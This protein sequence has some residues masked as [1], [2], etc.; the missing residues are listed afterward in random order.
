MEPTAQENPE[1]TP[2]KQ[3]TATIGLI[4]T[5]V[6]VYILTTFPEFTRPADWALEW[7]LFHPKAIDAGQWWRIVTASVLHADIAH[8]AMNGFAIYI[9]GSLIEPALGTRQMLVL[10][11]VSTIGTWLL[12]YLFLPSSSLGASGIGYGLMGAC[13]TLILRVQWLTG[14]KEFL[15][16][17]RGFGLYVLIFL[18]WNYMDQTTVNL[19]GHLGGFIAGVLYG[20]TGIQLAK[21][22]VEPSDS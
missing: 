13:F 6:V 12:S 3:L 15:Q 14:N 19:W 20:L 18:A 1:T 2:S 11:I 21:V 17:L 9:F 22:K 8:L 10:F 7:G 5:I 16:S 4:A